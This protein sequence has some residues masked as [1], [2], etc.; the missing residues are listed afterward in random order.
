VGVP[1]G[2]DAGALAGAGVPCVVFGPGSIQQA[3]TKDEWV[4][5][6][7]LQQATEILLDFCTGGA[8]EGASGS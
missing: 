1:F 2:T 3:H 7:Q 8:L 6:R 5:V 4:D